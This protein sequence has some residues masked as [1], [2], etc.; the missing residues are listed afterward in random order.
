MNVGNYFILSIHHF[1]HLSVAEGIILKLILKKW[2]GGGRLD[3][4]SSG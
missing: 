1:E 2:C 4:I 3:I